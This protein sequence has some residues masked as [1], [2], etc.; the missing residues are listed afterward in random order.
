VEIML[1]LHKCALVLIAVAT[2]TAAA[3]QPVWRAESDRRSADVAVGRFDDAKAPLADKVRTRAEATEVAVRHDLFLCSVPV[4][5]A[6]LRFAGIC[7][8]V[9]SRERAFFD[10]APPT[11]VA[12]GVLLLI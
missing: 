8:C 4:E 3:R 5:Y 6:R 1:A 2:L 11:L 12:D 9:C 10:L 7:R